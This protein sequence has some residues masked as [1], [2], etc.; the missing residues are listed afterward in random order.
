M[1]PNMTYFKD[2]NF[3][4]Q[5]SCFSKFLTQELKKIETPKKKKNA[6]SKPVLFIFSQSKTTERIAIF[7]NILSTVHVHTFNIF[8]EI[9]INTYKDILKYL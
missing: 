2:K 1:I 5:K 9:D 6:F 8:N 4:P 3:T 7:Q